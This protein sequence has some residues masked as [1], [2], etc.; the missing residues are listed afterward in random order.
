METSEERQENVKWQREALQMLKMNE[1]ETDEAI[2][3]IGSVKEMMTKLLT[4]A[5]DQIKDE[6]MLNILKQL[7]NYRKLLSEC[8]LEEAPDRPLNM[9]RLKQS[10]KADFAA[11]KR[12][13]D[14]MSKEEK[15]KAV[16]E[17]FMCSNNWDYTFV[18]VV[19]QTT[20]R[21]KL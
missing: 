12:C 10:L 19:D 11:F 16:W 9:E 1:E 20:V 5:Y 7:E 8:I 3:N 15:K 17:A 4:L 21:T 6:E 18:V 2:A 14:V 13:K